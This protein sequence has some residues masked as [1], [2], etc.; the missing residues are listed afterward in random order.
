MSDGQAGGVPPECLRVDLVSNGE[1]QMVLEQGRSPPLVV[2]FN[3][4]LFWL[5]RV[6][7]G[8]GSSL[9]AARGAPL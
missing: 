2:L 9:V 1:L 8:T 3:V 7:C 5:C 4:Y 6:H